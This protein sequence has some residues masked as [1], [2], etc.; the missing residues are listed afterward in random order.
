MFTFP[1]NKYAG[2]PTGQACGETLSEWSG[3][4]TSPGYPGSYPNN[5]DCSWTIHV[6]GAAQIILKFTD[7][8]LEDDDCKYDYLTVGSV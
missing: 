1:M 4:L 3:E 6:P 8:Q 7:F 5:L 2:M